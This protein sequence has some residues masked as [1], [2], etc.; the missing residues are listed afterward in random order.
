MTAEEVLDM[1]DIRRDMYHMGSKLCYT[2]AEQ[3]RVQVAKELAMAE[4]SESICRAIDMELIEM[5]KG[6]V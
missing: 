5:E 1:I 4:L 6:R 2:S 3:K